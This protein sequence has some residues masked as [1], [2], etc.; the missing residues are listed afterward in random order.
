M[1]G[2]NTGL[3]KVSRLATTFSFTYAGTAQI[4]DIFAWYINVYF[5]LAFVLILQGVYSL[6]KVKNKDKIRT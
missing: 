1:N 3:Q 2:A 4:F 5:T 6:Q